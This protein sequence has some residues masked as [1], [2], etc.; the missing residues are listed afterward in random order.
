[1]GPDPSSPLPKRPA[2]RE[3][4][5]VAMSSASNMSNADLSQGFTQLSGRFEQECV[6]TQNLYSAVDANAVVLQQI[7]AKVRAIEIQAS[8]QV[9][10]GEQTAGEL[11]NLRNTTEQYLQK[12]EAGQAA[13]LEKV[14]ELD[15]RTDAQLR[16]VLDAMTA[17][18]DSKLAQIS[19]DIA[20]MSA[21]ARK[22]AGEYL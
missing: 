14:A 13:A 11:A 9:A 10:K 17:Q 15:K 19:A 6:F 7:V 20:A 4:F 12:S 8:A 5:P 21:Q 18:V 2:N 3:S 22:N 1:M 16:L